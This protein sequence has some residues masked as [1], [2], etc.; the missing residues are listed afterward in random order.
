MKTFLPK[1][2]LNHGEVYR[3][4]V[5]KRRYR[6]L[7]ET[8]LNDCYKYAAAAAINAEINHSQSKLSVYIVK[9]HIS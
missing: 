2:K 4:P 7:F 5:F 9:C 6:K 3:I 8:I 1:K